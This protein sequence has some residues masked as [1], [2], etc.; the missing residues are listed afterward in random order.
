MAAS[1]YAKRMSSHGEPAGW[2]HGAGGSK[3]RE[4]HRWETNRESVV[5]GEGQKL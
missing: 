4:N 5:T 1:T 2:D 3:G